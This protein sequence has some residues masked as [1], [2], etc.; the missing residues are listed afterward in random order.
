MLVAL[1]G[2]S[3]LGLFVVCWA[4][5]GLS[6]SE[7]VSVYSSSLSAVLGLTPFPGSVCC[8]SRVAECMGPF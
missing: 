7:G 3:F 1:P 2:L 8:G 5:G 6:S 4:E